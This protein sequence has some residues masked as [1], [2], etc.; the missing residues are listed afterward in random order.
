MLKLQIGNNNYR[1]DDNSRAQ[2]I[3]DFGCFEVGLQYYPGDRRFGR[4]LD[5]GYGHIRGTKAS[6]GMALDV[7]VHRD[8]V[9]D[10]VDITGQPV[11]AIRQL[12]NY[13]EVDELKLGLGFGS[14]DEFER[15]YVQ[16][17]QQPDLVGGIAESVARSGIDERDFDFRLDAWQRIGPNQRGQRCGRGWEG[18]KGACKRAKP[19]SDK[20][21]LRKASAQALADKIRANKNLL[22]R[23]Q[24]NDV[25]QRMKAINQAS[26]AAVAKPKSKP[27]SKPEAKP[28][29]P[30]SLEAQNR[31]STLRDYEYARKIADGKVSLDQFMKDRGW[32]SK[33]IA[34][35]KSSPDYKSKD[36]VRFPV[37]KTTGYTVKWTPQE[38]RDWAEYHD[39]KKRGDAAIA[40]KLSGWKDY[41]PKDV[42]R[43]LY[44]RSLNPTKQADGSGS[45][46]GA[47]NRSSQRSPLTLAVMSDKPP[48]GFKKIDGVTVVTGDGGPKNQDAEW[49]DISGYGSYKTRAEAISNAKSR[50]WVDEE[51]G[52]RADV[53]VKGSAGSFYV[54]QRRRGPQ[55]YRPDFN[56]FEDWQNRRKEAAAKT[57]A[58][59]EYGTANSDAYFSTL[60]F[61]EQY[62]A[63]DADSF[64]RGQS[65]TVYGSSGFESVTVRGK[66]KDGVLLS[67]GLRLKPDQIYIGLDPDTANQY[68]SEQYAKVP[69]DTTGDGSKK[70]RDYSAQ[71]NVD[72]YTSDEAMR[73]HRAV[74]NNMVRGDYTNGAIAALASTGS[75]NFKGTA[76]YVRQA[77]ADNDFPV[78]AG[79]ISKSDF[80]KR[81]SDLYKVADQLDQWAKS[82]SSV[83]DRVK[84]LFRVDSMQQYNQDDYKSIGRSQRGQPCGR[85]WVGLKGACKRASKGT[86]AARKAL[87]KESAM[88]LASKIRSKKGLKSKSRSN[89]WADQTMSVRDRREMLRRKYG[90]EGSGS[91]ATTKGA[92][93]KRMAEANARAE[94][95][96]FERDIERTTGETM[97]GRA[98]RQRQAREMSDIPN[99]GEKFE[100]WVDDTKKR[101]N[102]NLDDP[103]RVKNA[104]DYFASQIKEYD[105]DRNGRI[106]NVRL[107]GEQP[108]PLKQAMAFSEREWN[109]QQIKSKPQNDISLGDLEEQAKQMRDRLIQTYGRERGAMEWTRIQME[110][111]L[112]DDISIEDI[113]LENKRMGQG[114]KE[115]FGKPLPK[116]RKRRKRRKS[117][118]MP[119]YGGPQDGFRLKYNPR[120]ERSANGK[121]SIDSAEQLRFDALMDVVEPTIDAIVGLNHKTIRLEFAQP[122][123]DDLLQEFRDLTAKIMNS[124]APPIIPMSEAAVSFKDMVKPGQNPKRFYLI[125]SPLYCN[126]RTAEVI[127]RDLEARGMKVQ[128]R[129]MRDMPRGKVPAFATDE[130]IS[131]MYE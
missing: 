124:E 39:I 58:A 80:D 11:Y 16:F 4:V 15:A 94:E 78:K 48:K 108:M 8:L 113:D 43:R 93:F 76:D 71:D 63:K 91:A 42:Q 120:G 27:K 12:D 22:P 25:R 46:S 20:A 98:A 87:I 122:V 56:P 107:R 17:M 125:L 31:A 83:P 65:V 111:A 47:N 18:L 59:R 131:E 68:R 90:A 57:K 67:N 51:K 74:S 26:K 106:S 103:N 45:G 2:K 50:Q 73:V 10:P 24:A 40:E 77:L 37:S 123:S 104:A 115:T 30:Q 100:S 33:T 34:E 116:S 1:V 21:A 129:D 54:M 38:S 7:Y 55:V 99:R 128:R 130:S 117:G 13:G 112:D 86:A 53:V 23:A 75:A 119:D 109:R 5:M 3:I 19:G 105:I 89:K 41:L 62:A 64:K 84:D 52:A 29:S 96:Q 49:R 97:R 35:I 66:G 60:K 44:D 95:K 32:T 85:G 79:R 69:S 92:K 102:A 28:K 82:P 70:Y 118:P 6:D 36:Y 110:N 126:E 81:R 9:L 88:D 127:A 114:Y 14:A 101:L 61:A 121:W 72:R